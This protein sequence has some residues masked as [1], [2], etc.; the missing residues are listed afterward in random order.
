[1]FVNLKF[2]VIKKTNKILSKVCIVKM[3]KKK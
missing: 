2:V 1:M 3:L